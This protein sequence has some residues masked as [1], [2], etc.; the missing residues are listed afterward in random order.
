MKLT[1]QVSIEFLTADSVSI[2]TR[3]FVE[4]IQLGDAHRTA[5]I[6]SPLGREQLQTADFDNTIKQAILTVWG[7]NPTLEDEPDEDD[8]PEEEDSA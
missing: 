3:T 1:T 8:I 4:D 5:F 7:K 6:N 2:A